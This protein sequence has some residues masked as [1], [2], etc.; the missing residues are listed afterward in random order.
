MVGKANKL[1][2]RYLDVEQDVSEWVANADEVISRDLNHLR[3]EF[4]GNSPKDAASG[5]KFP[6]TVSK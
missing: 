5:R 6:P 4:L 2:G 1:K 3:V